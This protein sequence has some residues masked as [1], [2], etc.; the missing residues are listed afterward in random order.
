[1]H[2][3]ELRYFPKIFIIDTDRGDKE[4][5][6]IIDN[7]DSDKKETAENEEDNI[8]DNNDKSENENDIKRAGQCTYGKELSA[9]DEEIW[10]Q[11]YYCKYEHFH[12]IYSNAKG[13]KKVDSM[14]SK[15]ENGSHLI[16]EFT[17]VLLKNTNK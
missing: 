8:V 17:K 1:M 5:K 7:N 2:Y 3:H 4:I 10:N 9:F 6:F 11:R 16:R 12:L 15:Q 14:D 13:Y